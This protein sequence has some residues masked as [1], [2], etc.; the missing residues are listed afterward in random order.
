MHFLKI[1]VFL[2]EVGRG[3]VYGWSL[4]VGLVLDSMFRRSDLFKEKLSISAL[5]VMS[6]WFRLNYITN[7]FYKRLYKL[8]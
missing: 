3:S 2:N 7:N 6:L 1:M 8:L 5:L 4:K